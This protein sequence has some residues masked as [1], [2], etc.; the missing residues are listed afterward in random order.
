MKLDLNSALSA[1][2]N[3]GQQFNPTIPV[4]ILVSPGQLALLKS[5]HI[6]KEPKNKMEAKYL[7]SLKDLT[8]QEMNEKLVRI[9]I[10][11]HISN[12]VMEELEKSAQEMKMGY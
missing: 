11:S 6:P 7:E 1:A 10:H 2:Q 5:F 12:L 8:D 4:T 3:V 9:A